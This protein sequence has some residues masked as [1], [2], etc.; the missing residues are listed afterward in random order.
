[1]VMTMVKKYNTLC[2]IELDYEK[3]TIG[4]RKVKLNIFKMIVTNIVFVIKIFT[5]GLSQF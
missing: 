1:M 3:N 2:F 5:P 4:H